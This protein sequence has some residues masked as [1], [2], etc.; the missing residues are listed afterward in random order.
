MISVRI[1]ST[2][3]ELALCHALR[4]LVFVE[5][6]G[7]PPHEEW[8]DRDG[9]CTHLLA[10]DGSDAIGTARL[11]VPAD[12]RDGV[13]AKAQR[14]AVRKTDRKRGVG[15][16]LMQALEQ[17]ARRRGCA[18]IV[19]GAQITALPFYARLGYAAYGPEFEDAGIPHRMMRKAV[20]AI[21]GPS[22][23][24]ADRSGDVVPASS[25]PA[26]T[27]RPGQPS[28]LALVIAIDDDA[29]SLYAEAGLEVDHL[30][31]S[32]PFVRDDH[33]KWARALQDGR[34]FVATTRDDEVVGFVALDRVDGR[35][36]VAQ[37]SVRRAWMRKRVG[38]QLMQHALAWASEAGE[39]W[40]TTYSHLPWNRPYYERF[41]F[42]VEPPPGPAL[43]AIL[44]TERAALDA[45]DERVAMVHRGPI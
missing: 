8:D 28:E 14:V 31:A 35:P 6:Q 16:A 12:P 36:Y 1:V 43:A 33:A 27:I 4:R 10:L 21:G 34:L 32:H 13:Q 7:V 29:S 40:L 41:G 2:K 5:E 25:R 22:P 15:R 45:P 19:L 9:V 11:Y 37:I 20:V 44:A 18:E 3:A 26:C 23:A 42:R 30:D 38:T 17:E 24:A 39:L